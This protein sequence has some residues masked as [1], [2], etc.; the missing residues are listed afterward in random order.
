[1]ST[2]ATISRVIEHTNKGL[3][4][5]TISVHWDGY[6]SGVGKKLLHYYTDESKIEDL[7]K[8]GNMSSLGIRVSPDPRFKHN[9][10]HPQNCTCVFYFRDRGEDW[11]ECKPY[12][13]TVKDEKAICNHACEEYNYL[14]KDGKWYYRKDYWDTYKLITAKVIN[15]CKGY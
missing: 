6:L 14:F 3:K 2:T 4:C 13:Y 1:M 11:S 7:F 9:F 10:D 8:N 12:V 5:Q 15:K